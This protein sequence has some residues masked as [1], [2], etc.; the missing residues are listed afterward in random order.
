[1][2]LATSRCRCDLG[3]FLFGIRVI[4]LWNSLPNKVILAE[5]VDAVIPR[6]LATNRLGLNDGERRGWRLNEGS[7]NEPVTSCLP[8][9]QVAT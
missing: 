6:Y 1:M 3:N 8:T 5:S 2:K 7:V 4:N 9:G